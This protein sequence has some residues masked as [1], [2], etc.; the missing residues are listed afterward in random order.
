MVSMST[1]K[2]FDPL[3]IHKHYHWAAYNNLELFSQY[4]EEVF[5]VLFS[6]SISINA[7]TSQCSWVS[8]GLWVPSSINKPWNNFFLPAKQE[9]KNVKCC[10]SEIYKVNIIWYPENKKLSLMKIILVYFC[11]YYKI[12][13]IDGAKTEMLM[14]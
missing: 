9:R 3:T 2:T 14:V 7:I 6:S 4:Q 12:T 13:K 11:I 5:V 1:R 8:S 10:T